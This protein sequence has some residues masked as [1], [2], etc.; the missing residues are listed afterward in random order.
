VQGNGLSVM[1]GHFKI[2]SFVA[3]IEHASSSQ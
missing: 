3:N 2:R 1:I